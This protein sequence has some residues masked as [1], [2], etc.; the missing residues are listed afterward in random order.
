MVNINKG[1]RFTIRLDWISL[2]LLVV[3][4]LSD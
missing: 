1:I 3:N 4:S 2:L